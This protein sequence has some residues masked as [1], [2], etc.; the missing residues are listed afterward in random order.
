ML[1]EWFLLVFCDD[2]LLIFFF[3]LVFSLIL[4]MEFIQGIQAISKFWST[5]RAQNLKIVL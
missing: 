1:L 2:D 3:D 5:A 4:F